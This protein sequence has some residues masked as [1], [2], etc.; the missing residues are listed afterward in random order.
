MY[1]TTFLRTALLLVWSLLGIAK[2]SAGNPQKVKTGIYL[3]NIYDLDIN[4]HSYY[5][6]FYIWFKW[7]G[8]RDPTNI[9]FVNAVEKWGFT[10]IP[11]YEEAK[12]M[13]DGSRY[14]GMRIEGRFYHPF[15][16]SCFPLDRH[17]LQI[18]IENA[19]FPLDSLVY[20]P[21]SSAV[22]VRNGFWLP[23][24]N[25][26]KAQTENHANLYPTDFGE[27]GIRATTYS[28][29]TFDLPISR[30]MNYF[31]LKLFLPL[32]IV[33]LLSLGALGIYPE[34]TDARISVP[35]GSLLAVVFLQQSY[36]LAYALELGIMLRVVTVGNYIARSKK[37]P[38]F[39]TI[40]RRD[41]RSI[42]L[43]LILMILG[44]LLLI[45]C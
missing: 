39:K 3:M 45:W 43:Y 20:V 40:R 23:G 44:T 37:Q 10:N 2:L 1:R 4:T 18:Q 15:E 12:E 33:V 7:T 27:T 30:P 25:I 34:R 41:I 5:A 35:I 19:D 31:L 11:F 28:N 26:G 36:E 29:F 13:P 32:F 42:W 9:E 8:D 22:F 6:D 17:T 21:D 38:D 24:W 14:N 16:L